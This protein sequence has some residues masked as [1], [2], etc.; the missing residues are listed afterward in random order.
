MLESESLIISKHLCE[1]AD[2]F[3]CVFSEVFSECYV[4]LVG[5]ADEVE[6]LLSGL[7]AESAGISCEVV[8]LLS[9]C[10]CVHGLEVVV[11]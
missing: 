3:D 10:A 4:D 9:G 11:E 6:Y 8:E 2:V 1:F 5:G 7:Y